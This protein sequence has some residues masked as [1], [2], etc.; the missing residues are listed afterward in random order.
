MR[1]VHQLKQD[2]I[3]DVRVMHPDSGRNAQFQTTAAM[4]E[5]HENAKRIEYKRDCDA[6]GKHFVPFVVIRP[7]ERWD[8]LR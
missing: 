1:G 2:A 6:K 7:T 8:I 3:V 4:L 5:H